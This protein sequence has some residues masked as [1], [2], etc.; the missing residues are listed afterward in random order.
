[1]T[2]DERTLIHLEKI[3]ITPRSAPH[4]HSLAFLVTQTS[5]FT[6]TKR[7]AFPFRDHSSVPEAELCIHIVCYIWANTWPK[8]GFSRLCT[9]EPTYYGE[10]HVDLGMVKV[11]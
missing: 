5:K 6:R 10:Y 7:S 9:I 1:M 11:Q 2:F 8:V 4:P 3:D